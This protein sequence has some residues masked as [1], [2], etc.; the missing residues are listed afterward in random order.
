MV[1][2]PTNTAA[3][4]P[5]AA[6]KRLSTRSCRASRAREASPRDLRI[7]DTLGWIRYQRGSF[8]A[9]LPELLAAAAKLPEDA[10]V[11]FHLGMVYHKLDRSEPA[12]ES[13]KR[14]LALGLAGE[15]AAQARKAIAAL[16]PAPPT[17]VP[18]ATP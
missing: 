15:D 10:T 13:L 11:Q 3:T 12:R 5:A 14:A 1:H 16:P 2:R 6:S 7:A 17:P 18:S 4:P 9:A 8:E